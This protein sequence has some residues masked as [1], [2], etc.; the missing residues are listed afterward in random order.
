MMPSN[1]NSPTWYRV[2][3]LKPQLQEHITVHRHEYR[4]QAWFVLQDQHK[5][6]SHR[7]NSI[8]YFVIS[9]MNGQRSM[10][11][12]WGIAQTRFA[13]NPP[14][15]EEMVSLL[16]KLY[17]CELVHTDSV[18]DIEELSQRAKH[19]SK[20]K[21]K[22]YFLNP[23]SLRFPLFNPETFLNRNITYINFLFKKR[24][25]HIWIMLITL[26]LLLM[27]INWPELSTATKTHAFTTQN[28]MMFLFIYPLVKLLHE[29]GH[30]FTIKHY[31][32]EVTEMGIIFMVFVPLPYVNAH[33]AMALP[34]KKQ[35]MLI[36]AI[37]IIVEST[38]AALALLLWLTIEP[39]LLRIICL[40]IM[41]I[42][43]LSTLFMNGN[44]LLKFDGYHVLTDAIES[45]NLATRA[46]KYFS[47]KL[48]QWLFKIEKDDDGLMH[49]NEAIW[50]FTYAL[51]A[52]AYRIFIMLFILGMVLEKF[53]AA[54][55]VLVIWTVTLQFI[56][57]SWRYIVQLTTSEKTSKN[58]PRVYSV[59][60]VLSLVLLLTLFII[61]MPQTSSTQGIIWISEEMQVKAQSA[62]FIR[63]MLVE[64][65]HTVQQ[66]ESLIITE[67]PL[68]A[69]RIKILQAQLKELNI[70]YL[71]K[72][73]QHLEAEQFK[74]N[75][76]TA[77][78]ELALHK[79]RLASLT[80][81]SPAD[82]R[83]VIPDYLDLPDQFVKQ[84][85]ILG[86]ILAADHVVAQIIIIEQ[87]IALFKQAHSEFEIRPIGQPD[88]IVTARYSHLVP[89]AIKQLPSAALGV[90][91]GGN[92]LVDPADSSG[93]TPLEKVF[94]LELSLPDNQLQNYIGSR[95]LVRIKHGN[96]PLAKQWRRSLQQL[97]LGR[98]N[99]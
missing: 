82:G 69:G 39:G 66:G 10:Q 44:P 27:I 99:V 28:I 95:V 78:I 76:A 62:G 46:K 88:K 25:F 45:P 53:Y 87:E 7:F 15:Q 26:A 12:L 17:H 6:R 30:A 75:I 36:S 42:G 33:S 50:F 54:G 34:D 57:P 74:Q 52:F 80:I 86:F 47:Y 81:K 67:D 93:R 70:K 92:I 96:Q 19:S 49:D 16:S 94:Q 8:A 97:F 35:R 85:Q 37:G 59:L 71:A 5:A 41:L 20:Q 14:S 77:E 72:R 73:G 23:L 43:G 56:L 9:S 38:L 29:L 22:Q 18:P 51:A 31:G 61:P 13:D 4:H 83:L 2:A 48:H 24:M 55:I 21:I 1:I 60:A 32:G 98:F 90:Q 63:N 64:N 68:L 65:N 40:D 79:H 11:E 91:G 84:G 89:E 3:E 58:R